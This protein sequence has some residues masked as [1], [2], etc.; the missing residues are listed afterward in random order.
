[1]KVSN[2]GLVVLGMMTIGY[3]GYKIYQNPN[4]FAL[5]NSLRDTIFVDSL[6]MGHYYKKTIVIEH[7]GNLG[8]NPLLDHN[9]P[10]DY[11]NYSNDWD[12]DLERIK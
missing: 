12:K 4:P 3:I 5:Q 6:P 11:D 2:V 8:T 10:T 9:V 1:M 7:N